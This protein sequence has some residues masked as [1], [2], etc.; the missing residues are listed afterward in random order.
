M[1]CSLPGYSI[2]GILQARILEWVAFS[3]SSGEEGAL[4]ISLVCVGSAH[5]VWATLGLLPLTVCVFSQPTL[6]RLQVVLQGNCLKWAL[7]F[8]HFPSLSHSGSGSQVLHKGTNSVGPAFC[9]LPGPSSS[10]NQM[11]GERTLPRYDASY[12]LPGTSC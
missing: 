9:A 2:H 10:G 3:F 11:L 12:G 7:D 5:S 6:L 8:V 4:Q 1:D